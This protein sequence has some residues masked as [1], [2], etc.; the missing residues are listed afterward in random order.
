[1]NILTPIEIKRE[2]DKEVVGQEHAKKVL[3]IEVFK[4]Y[5]KI[6]NEDKLN[7]ME[8]Q[9]TK[10]NILMTGLTGTGKTHLAKTIA[11]LL[12]VP[13]AISDMTS[14]TAAGYVGDD[15]EN[16]IH[17]LLQ[18]CDF[19][20]YAAQRGICFLDEIDKIGRKGE[21]PSLTRDVS[22]E[23]VQQAILKMLEGNT[24]TVPENGGRKHPFGNN[25]SFDTT[26][27]LFIGGGSFEGV[28]D[29]V[30]KRM[31]LTNSKSIGFNAT[32]DKSKEME[33]KEIRQ[34]ITRADL[35]KFGM[36]PELLGR[37][38]I[39]T[40]LLPLEK[41]D[42]VNILKLQNGVIEEYK[43]LFSLQDKSLV[44]KNDLYEIIADISLEEK[45]GARGLKAIIESCMMELLFMA[46]SDKKKKYIIDKKFIEENYKAMSKI[47]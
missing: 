9:L 36:L 43:T 8:K 23:G 31:G 22:G 11:G 46:P 25:I 20:V 39:L 13:F 32:N 19:D 17:R 34:S 7:K 12:E 28:E 10:S 3:S 5:M 14:L 26:N 21:N 40:N 1:M 47:A 35:H 30:R 41:E 38:T 44:V 16:I 33:L 27:V 42:L 18:E 24:I 29:I 2:L 15:V 37:F 45:V 4:H 6:E